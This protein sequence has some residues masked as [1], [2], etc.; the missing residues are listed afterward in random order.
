MDVEKTIEFIL[1]HQARFSVEMDRAKEEMAEMRSRSRELQQQNAELQQRHSELQEQIES[2]IMVQTMMI[3]HY[4]ESQTKI[5]E[6]VAQLHRS[7]A[8]TED[9]L[10]ALIAV[11]DGLVRRTPPTS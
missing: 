8:A 11:V 1:E 9:R 2:V 3:R 6:S 4:D 10:G 5:T 7:Q